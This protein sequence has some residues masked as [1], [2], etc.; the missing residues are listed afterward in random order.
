MFLGHKISADSMKPSTL[1]LKGIAKMALP[2]NYTEV[3]HFLGMT[4]FFWR[5]IKNYARIAKPLNDILE[6]EASKMK[7]EAVTLPPEALEAFEWLKMCCMMAPVLAFADF[8]KEF[9]LETD[10]SSEGLGTMLS[11]KQPDGKWHPITFGSRELKGGEAK[12]HSSKLEFLALKWAIMEQFREYLQYLPFTMLTDNNPLTYILTTPNLD[13]LGYRWVATLA[14]Y[15]MTIKY[16]KGSDNKV[17]DALSRIE[18]RL[19]PETVTELLNHMKGDA[20]RAKVEDIRIIEEEER[21]DQEVIHPTTQLA[22]QDK[23][24]CNLHTE[25]WRQAQ[26]MDPVIPHVLEWLRLPKNDRTRLKDFLQGKVSEADCQAY[27]L[28]EKDFEKRDHILFIK[29]TPPGSISTI[30]VFVVPV[31]QRQVAIDMCHRGARHQGRDQS[32]SLMKE[33]FWW[34]GMANALFL[35]I[36]NCSRCKQFEAKY[37]IPEMEPILCTQPMELVHVDY[38]GMEVTVAAQE[39]TSDSGSF[40]P[41]CPGLFSR[42]TIR[43]IPRPESCTTIYFPSS[44]FPRS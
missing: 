44:G 38:V 2:A 25:D 35:V 30:P 37:Q 10:V 31:N 7:S 28:R 11:Q 18:T 27:G 33:W 29:T 6:G 20:P 26:Q 13:V 3:R 34:P 39:R 8:E 36:Q 19:D 17:A 23:K 4:G 5:F 43:P 32:L 42:I 14:S 21:A 40:H 24:F 12:Y 41:V 16:L 9:Q 22:R 1:N 15:N